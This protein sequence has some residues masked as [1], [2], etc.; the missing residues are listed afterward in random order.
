M[1]WLPK[2]YSRYAA[3]SSLANGDLHSMGGEGPRLEYTLA[4]DSKPELRI[5]EILI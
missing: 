4:A 1:G 3:A 5:A 2:D